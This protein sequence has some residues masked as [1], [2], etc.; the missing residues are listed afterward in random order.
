MVTRNR[1]LQTAPSSINFSAPNY[2]DIV[3]VAVTC[4]CLLSYVYKRNKKGNLQ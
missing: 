3:R 4:I 2:L 1:K